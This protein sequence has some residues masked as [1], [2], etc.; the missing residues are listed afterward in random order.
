MA[1]EAKALRPITDGVV[2]IRPF[3]TA[4]A[5]AIV[6]GRD[7]EFHRW[8]GAGSP[9]PRPTACIEVGGGLVGWVD[10][11]RHEDHHWLAPGE[12]NV[13]YAL[14]PGHR[15]HGYASRSVQLLMH[16]LAGS[17]SVTTASLLIDPANL[18]S[19]AL[20]ARTG[21]A[22]HGD[23]NGQVHLRRPVPPVTYSDGVVTIRPPAPEDL[24]PDLEA[25]DEEQIRWLWPPGEGESWAAWSETERRDHAARGLEERAG[26]FGT[27]PKWTFTVDAVTTTYVAYADCDLA[28][29]HV[30]AG[31][32]NISYSAHPLHRGRGY[33]SRAVRLVLR[34]LADNT[35]CRE[36]HI[37]AD[38]ENTASRR[39]ATAVGAVEVER[40]INEQGR[41]MIRHVVLVGR[42]SGLV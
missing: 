40:Y 8:M 28:N 15:G 37:V 32:A 21:F 25:K 35:G 41:T 3:T 1:D 31:E 18:A 23:V 20:A 5:A 4:D 26:A 42:G 29:D 9:E 16:H 39:V 13:G 19:L 30:P 14:F 7:D 36:A 22:R 12:V 33:V 17:S 11:D 27:G 24:E 38:E 6:A 10:Y 34:F 2:R